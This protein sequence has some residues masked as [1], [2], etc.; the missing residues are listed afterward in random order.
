MKALLLIVVSVLATACYTPKS[1]NQ[2]KKDYGW[3]G[4]GMADEQDAG[5]KKQNNDH[6]NFGTKRSGP[7]QECDK[8]G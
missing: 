6:K 2:Q 4:P 3:E 8:R 5:K 7:R 1:S